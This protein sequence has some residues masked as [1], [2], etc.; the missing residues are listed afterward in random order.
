[1]ISKIAVEEYQAIYLKQ[2]GKT[3]SFEE[4]EFQAANLLR[5]YKAVLAPEA[6]TNQLNGEERTATK[7]N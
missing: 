5:L 2:Y 1:M 6:K 3:L 7:I 4:A